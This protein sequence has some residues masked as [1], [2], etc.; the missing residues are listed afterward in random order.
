MQ[1]FWDSISGWARDN[2]VDFTIT[3][4]YIACAVAGG[5][6]LIAQTGL[7]LFGLGGDSDID[8]DIDVD[9]IDGGDSLSFLSIRALAGFM[10]FFG[11]VGWMGTGKEW[12]TVITAG[13]AFAAGSSVMFLIAFLMRFFRRMASSGNVKPAKAVGKTANV[14][15]RIPADN[16]GKGKIT[17][18]LQDRSMEFDA[19]TKGAELPTGSECRIVAM[20]TEGTFEVAPLD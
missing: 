15:L 18:R 3:K 11:L 8:P 9:D 1:E 5:T 10:T 13:A 19:V 12:G 2:L 16:Q 14:Y 4:M 7:N 6:V 20:I 17:V